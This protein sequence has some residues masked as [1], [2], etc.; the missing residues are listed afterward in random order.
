MTVSER[1]E[2]AIELRRQHKCNC[3]QAVA[4]VLADQ[5]DLSEEDLWNASAGFAGG[6]G[7]MEGVCGALIGAVIVAGLKQKDRSSVMTANELSSRFRRKCG[8]IICRKLKGI[9]TG[10][11]LCPCEECIRNAISV[12]GEV[13]GLEQPDTQ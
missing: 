12:F 11:V 3:S 8:D 13:V 6:M 10:S 1:A 7:N 5:T 2:L 9:E 4:V